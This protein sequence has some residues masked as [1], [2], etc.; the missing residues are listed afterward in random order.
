MGKRRK[1]DYSDDRGDEDYV[2]KKDENDVKEVDDEDL[3]HDK[4]SKQET[5]KQF[6]ESIKKILDM[7][8]KQ[9]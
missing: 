7:W 2:W 5:M 9:I 1:L 4:S 6:S 3:D 8:T